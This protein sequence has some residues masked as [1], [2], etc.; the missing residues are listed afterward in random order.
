MYMSQV[1][2]LR[3]KDSGIRIVDPHTVKIRHNDE[4]HTENILPNYLLV[5]Y[6]QSYIEKND[7]NWTLE[8]MPDLTGKVIAVTGGNSGLGYESVKAFA[9]KGAEVVL[10][11][12]TL[13]KGEAAKSEILKTVPEGKISVMQLELGDL[14]SVREFATALKKACTRLDVLLNNAGIMMTPYFTTKDGF[15]GQFGTNHLGHFALT[16][17]LMDLL[18]R[19]PGSRVVNVSSGAHRNGVMDFNNLQYE[20]GEGY[21]PTKAYGRSKLSN[22]L[23]TYE[24]QRK[25]EA[26]GKDTIAVAAHPGVAMTNLARHLQDRLLFK[27]LKPVF[28]WM[29][30]D[31]AMGALP[32]IRASVDPGVLGGQYY[33]PDGRRELKGYP[34][35]VPSNDASHNSEDASRL[36]EESERLTGVKFEWE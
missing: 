8:N 32:Q 17:L 5:F 20:Q 28:K 24:L 26:S 22:L 9:S 10:A 14:G 19:T 16:G 6:D 30:Q 13:E 23:F 29:T 15:E 36:W 31:Q 4:R 18:L 7:M 33:G 25:L 21:T 11:S 1:D 34:V 27:V 2:H 35:V 3:P 12:R